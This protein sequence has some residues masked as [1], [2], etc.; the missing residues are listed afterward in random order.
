MNSN[1]LLQ[2][3]LKIKQ[4]RLNQAYWIKGRLNWK[5]HSAQLLIYNQIKNLSDEAREALIF[6]ARGFGKSYLGIILALEDCLQ[7]ENIQV[8]IIGPSAKHT[9]DIV[10]PLM[11][12]IC[13][14]APY[15]LITQYRSTTTWHFANGSILSIGGFDTALE[16]FRG[17]TLYNIYLEE[18]GF[19]TANLDDY[20]YL[21]YSVL[22]NCLR[23][24]LGARI[25]HLTTPARLVDHPLHLETLPK[26]KLTDT[27]YCYTIQDN[28]R[29]TQEQIDKEIQ[30]LGGPTSI[31]TKREL[32]CLIER[33]DA[34]TI[35]PQFEEERHVCPLSRSPNYTYLVSGDLGY[36]ADKSA[37]HL[38]AYD[39]DLGKVVVLEEQWFEATKASKELADALKAKW[40]D[41]NPT[42]AVDYQGNAWADFSAEGISLIFPTKDK[43]DATYANLR[44]EFFNDKILIDPSCQLLIQTLRSGTFNKQKTDYLRTATLGHCDAMMSLIYGLRHVDKITDLR[45]RPNPFL[46]FNR[47]T[48]SPLKSQL[49]KLSHL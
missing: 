37:F 47:N 25:V 2:E 48:P 43:F 35:I 33:D 19:S 40:G 14:D 34:I 10:T 21:L 13:Q 30:T 45:P 38:M 24:R 23:S 16:S 7:N 15:G 22:M 29:L 5:L 4:Q 18:T 31:S 39:H 11:N 8:A 36:K 46:I 20:N 27:F 12:L 6:C 49:A 42:Y 41:L 28:P 9:K 17:R 3:A 32:F 26:C 1:P 44:N